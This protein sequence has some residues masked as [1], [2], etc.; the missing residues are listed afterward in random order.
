[1]CPSQK[2]TWLSLIPKKIF[3]KVNDTP[4]EDILV[5]SG[6]SNFKYN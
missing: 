3:I 2:L 6:N 5:I 4:V 1:M